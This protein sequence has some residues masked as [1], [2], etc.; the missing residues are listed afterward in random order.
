MKTLLLFGGL[1][2]LVASAC[3]SGSASAC[4][5]PPPP[6]PWFTSDQIEAQFAERILAGQ[7]EAWEGAT[8]VF[9]ARVAEQGA[10]RIAPQ[11]FGRR[12]VL[13]PVL[14]LKGPK[15]QRRI[16]IR[17]TG[18]LCGMTPGFDALREDAEGY[19]VVYS[20]ADRPTNETIWTT[21]PVNDLVEPKALEAWSLATSP[22]N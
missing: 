20:G 19:F 2:T 11:L 12:A 10:I 15:V 6:P 16:T 4:S 9:I 22:G 3:P 13:I 18:Y 5:P 1:F 21:T 8:T 17:H 7:R 14:Q